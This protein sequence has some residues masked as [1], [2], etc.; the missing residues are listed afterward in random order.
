[1]AEDVSMKGCCF[2]SAQQQE[3]KPFTL[4]HSN[5][6]V[7]GFHFA[8]SNYRNLHSYHPVVKPQIEVSNGADAL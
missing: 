3:I 2:L 7:Q 5:R 1:L 8:E 4:L 6:K